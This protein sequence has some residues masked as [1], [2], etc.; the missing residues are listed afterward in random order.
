MTVFILYILT[1]LPYTNVVWD[2]SVVCVVVDHGNRECYQ[3]KRFFLLYLN[4]QFWKH[5]LYEMI[6]MVTGAVFLVVKWSGCRP[7]HF[8]WF[9]THSKKPRFYKILLFPITRFISLITVSSSITNH[10]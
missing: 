2:S 1:T 10:F 4:H 9:S 6:K 5:S 3:Q 8:P 7:L